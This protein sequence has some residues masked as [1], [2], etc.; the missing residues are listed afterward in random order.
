MIYTIYIS[1]QSIYKVFGAN[2]CTKLGIAG[3]EKT[4]ISCPR[5]A[6]RYDGGPIKGLP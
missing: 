1:T 4:R 5:G 6:S 3:M 2:T